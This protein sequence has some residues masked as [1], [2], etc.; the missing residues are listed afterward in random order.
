MNNNKIVPFILLVL[1]SLLFINHGLR[2]LNIVPLI[3]MV[4]ITYFLYKTA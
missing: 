4:I 3:P 2:D 1:I